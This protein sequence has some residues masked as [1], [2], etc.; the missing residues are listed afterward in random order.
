VR[1]LLL[2]R[3]GPTAATR[4]DVFPVDEPLDDDGIAAAALLADA[5]PPRCEALSSPAL[6]CRQT[7]DAAGLRPAVVP[8]LAECDLGAWAGRSLAEIDEA[9]AAAWMIDPESRPHGG[10]SLAALVIRVGGWLD[11]Q[12]RLGGRAVAITHAGVIKAALVH[13][14]GAPLRAFWR[15]DA[16]PL[17]ITELHAHD[18]RWT[19]TRVNYV[20]DCARYASRTRH[21]RP[22]AAT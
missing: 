20:A 3:H 15:I 7:A 11:D 6:R 4:A 8:A 17:S 22:G 13:A 12:A 16:A 21:P 10:E 2:V 19:I 18:G 1:R 14:L 9:A 5:L